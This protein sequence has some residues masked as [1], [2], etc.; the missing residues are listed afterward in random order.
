MTHAAPVD[1]NVDGSEQ[2]HFVTTGVLD[3]VALASSI[4]G[5]RVTALA[6]GTIAGQ[7]LDAGLLD[8]VAIDLAPVVLG[9]GRRYFGDRD[10][11]TAVLGDATEV[12]AAPRVTHLTYPVLDR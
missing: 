9:S 11:S 5:D 1:W 12:I 2:F 4:A 6:A 10:L 3:A 7:V 8:I